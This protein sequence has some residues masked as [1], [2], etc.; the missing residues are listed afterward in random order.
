MLSL[1]A[2]AISAVIGF[3][4]TIPFIASAQN[5]YPGE[6]LPCPNAHLATPQEAAAASPKG[7]I[8]AGVTYVCPGDAALGISNAA[9]EAKDYLRTILCKPDDDNFGGYGPDETIRRL[10]P[11]FA[12]CAATFLK[13]LNTSGNPYCIKEGAR[14]VEKQNL[15]VARGVIAC[16]KGAA[17]EHPR[18]IAIDINVA[19]KP[20]A[21]CSDYT[22]A[23]QLAP[24]FGLTFYMGCKDAYHFVPQKGGCTDANFVP[25][26]TGGSGVNTGGT[27]G[28]LPA[29]YYDY[30]Q[31]APTGAASPYSSA[32]GALTPLLSNSF[33][34]PTQQP[35]SYPTSYPSSNTTGFES[36]PLPTATSSIFEVPPP[37]SYPL[38]TTSTKN[39]TT[40]SSA[41][42][43]IQLIAGG[44]STPGTS[45]GGTQ[46]GTSAPTQLN[47]DLYDIGAS[48]GGSNVTVDEGVINTIADNSVAVNPIHVTETFSQGQPTQVSP[49]KATTTNAVAN[50]PLI[51]ALLTTLRDLLVSFVNVL[52]SRSSAGFQG[53]W[54][55]IPA[56]PVYH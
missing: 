6:D 7:S 46:T 45:F 1:R 11:K 36:T 37:Y 10:D 22:R 27:N 38:A 39:T 34:Q 28:Y 48:T 19:N 55:A 26:T 3:V 2:G 49:S 47:P 50:K 13:S 24:Q 43:Q 29:S 15:Y 41:F 8:I 20:G 56:T 18:G 33:S 9:G 44:S 23:H 35:T 17:C 31:Y 4:L 14:T 32:F 30:P 21:P 54:Q 12:Q 53:S 5:A 51:V 25:S 40:G 52:K 42:D 16:T